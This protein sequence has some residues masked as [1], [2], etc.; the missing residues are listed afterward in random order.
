LSKVRIALIG[1]G[2]FGQR[3]LSYLQREA[4]AQLVAIADPNPAAAD[5]AK[6]QGAPYF[7]DYREMLDRAKPEGAII[8]SPNAL[9]APMGLACAER[10]VHVLVEKPIADTLD[11]AHR[12][13]SAAKRA[14]I[15]LLVGHHRRYNPVIEKARDIV[16]GGGIGRLITVVALWLIRKPDHYFD[17]AWRREAGGGPVLIN[18][19]HDIDD[20]RFICGEIDS[21]QAIT[22]NAIRGFPVEDTMVMAL[23][24]AGGALGTVTLSDTVPA[25]WSWELTS[26]ESPVYPQQIENCYLFS[27]T[28]GSLAVPKL[29]LWRYPGEQ[30]W[31]VPLVREAIAVVAEDPLLRQLRHFCEV[32]RG[33]ATPRIT[34][35]DAAH[36]LAATLAVHDAARSGMTIDLSA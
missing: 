21:V 2:A 27:G 23:R 31:N 24:F 26:G 14:G 30:S 35:A 4:R 36:T 15:A 25:P 19:I 28:A 10:G 5:V 6:A 29:E 1:A 3:H 11:A 7:A 32:I 16:R 8:V 34:G 18:L 20:L 9:H 12:L 13:A 22:S 33:E 17:V